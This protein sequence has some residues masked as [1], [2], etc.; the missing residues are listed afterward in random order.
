M[1]N[2][3]CVQLTPNDTYFADCWFSGLKTAEQMMAEGVDYC[4]SVK[5][6]H[7]GSC[8]AT[9]ENLM[10]YCPRGS[11][12]VMKSNPRVPVGGPLLDIGY[13]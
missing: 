5:T 13:K 6:S 9:L 3:R 1:A 4:G 11:Y 12:F 8:L 2:K 10:T 7:K